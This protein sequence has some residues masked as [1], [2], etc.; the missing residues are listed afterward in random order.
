[1]P[2]I[3]EPFIEGEHYLDLGLLILAKERFQQ[4]LQIATT[5]QDAQGIGVCLFYLIQVAIA[6]KN[7]PEAIHFLQ[8]A[9]EH[10]H[11]RNHAQML[12]QLELLSHEIEKLTEPDQ[13]EAIPTKEKPLPENPDPFQLYEQGAI[14]EAIKIFKKDVQ[15][16][17]KKNQ[18]DKVALSLLYLGQCH[19]TNNEIQKAM[20]HLKEAEKIAQEINDQ[21]LINAIQKVFDTIHL[22]DHQTDIDQ[23][24]L[25]DLLK[26]EP[27][28][29]KKIMLALSK[30]EIYIIKN[31]LKEAEFA[32]HYARQFIPE[33]NPEKY[34][35]LIHLVE[36]KF[37]R[38]KKKPEQAA[39]VLKYA[40]EFAQKSNANDILEMIQQTEIELQ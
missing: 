2:K 1:M 26:N 38:L 22:I 18:H 35:A 13:V 33:K 6:E 16:F 5:K 30:A 9:R 12:S 3:F 17:R 34:L 7:K 4:A 14:E 11:H 23:I 15:T 28:P 29:L 10:Y 39:I 8:K 40:K 20:T 32:I 25:E 31:N 19:F 21:N 27:D 36:S 24:S 37:L